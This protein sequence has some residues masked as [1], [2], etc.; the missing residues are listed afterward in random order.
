MISQPSIQTLSGTRDSMVLN[1]VM[2]NGKREFVGLELKTLP[3]L[4][5]D[6]VDFTS[7]LKST[8]P[9]TNHDGFAMVK[10]NFAIRTRAQMPRAGRVVVLIEG[11]NTPMAVILS[12]TK[13]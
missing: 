4:K 2:V 5:G 8:E 6:Q 13:Q 3:K 1:T 7:S 11:T 10:T 9:M 12:A